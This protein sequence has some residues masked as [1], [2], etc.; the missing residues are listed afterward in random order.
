MRVGGEK[1]WIWVFTTPS[2]T[3]VVIR[4]SRGKKVL[5]EVL[6]KSYGGIIVCDGHKSYSNYTSRLQ[7]CWAHLLREAKDLA[8]KIPEAVPLNKAL[9][10]LYK[11][12]TDALK[13]GPPLDERKRLLVNAKQTLSRWAEKQYRDEKTQ[14]FAGKIHNGLIHFLTFIV[15]QGVEPTNNR[16]ERA[17]REHVVIRKIIGTLRNTKGTRIHETIMTCLTTWKQQE[18]NSNEEII[19]RMS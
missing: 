11:K 12:L 6:G 3:L 14:K 19:K 17:L 16:A 1:Y 9:H 7:R 15:E 10:R 5:K 4:H 8:E 2:E 13:D 18:Q